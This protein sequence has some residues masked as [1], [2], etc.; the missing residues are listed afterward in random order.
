MKL[1]Q[2]IAVQPRYQVPLKPAKIKDIKDLFLY[3]KH[4][5]S[6]AALTF[7]YMKLLQNIAVQ[8]GYQVPLKSAEMKDIKD[9]FL[10]MK[11]ESKQFY[12]GC[13]KVSA[14]QMEVSCSLMNSSKKTIP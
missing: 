7:R 10:Y 9:L 4:C 6:L 1:L 8:P 11:E 14:A 5:V 3:L 13:T 2:N 12:E